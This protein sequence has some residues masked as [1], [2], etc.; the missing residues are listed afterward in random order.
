MVIL[1]VYNIIPFGFSLFLAR[2]RTSLQLLKKLFWLRI[3]D[4]GSVPEMRIWS[5]LLIKSD[6]K[7]YIH[8][9]RSLFLYIQNVCP[10]DYTKTLL[11]ISELFI[12][13]LLTL[14]KRT[15]FSGPIFE[16]NYEWILLMFSTNNWPSGWSNN[17]LNF[18]R[19]KLAEHIL[20]YHTG[21]FVHTISIT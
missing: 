14:Y 9:S 5:I 6:L 11:T 8:F 13:V 21:N 10:F 12:K 18:A 1:L 7:W 2:F 17:I 19:F 20:L 15:C 4:K 3:T 16:K